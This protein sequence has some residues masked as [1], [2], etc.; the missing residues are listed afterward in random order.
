MWKRVGVGYVRVKTCKPELDFEPDWEI[1]DELNSYIGNRTMF[2]HGA[3]DEYVDINNKPK[4]LLM[5]VEILLR[6]ALLLRCE[7]YIIIWD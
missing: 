2:Q 3:N 4:N 6:L 5:S 7:T 1:I